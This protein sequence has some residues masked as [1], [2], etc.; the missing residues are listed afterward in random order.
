MSSPTHTCGVRLTPGEQYVLAGDLTYN[1]PLSR[2]LTAELQDLSNCGGVYFAADLTLDEKTFLE[3]AVSD[4]RCSC[5]VCCLYIHNRHN[6]KHMP[7]TISKGGKMFGFFTS[8]ESAV[9]WWVNFT[10][11]ARGF[12][13]KIQM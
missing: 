8:L 9:R 11:Y 1:G 13:D 6:I 3:T 4:D 7:Q 5:K 10:V 2:G 12:Q